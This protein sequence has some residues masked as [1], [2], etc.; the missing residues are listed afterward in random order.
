[1]KPTELMF[2]FDT[3]D[4]TSNRSADAIVDLAGIMTDEGVT[5]HFAAVEV[6]G[7]RLI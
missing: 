7:L 3:E 2:F 5:G 1:M 6:C 4:F